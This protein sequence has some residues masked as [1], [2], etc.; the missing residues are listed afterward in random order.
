MAVAG[1]LT[2]SHVRPLQ[3]RQRRRPPP[4]AAEEGRYSQIGPRR[5]QR[6]HI[7]VTPPRP[8]SGRPLPISHA[9]PPSFTPLTPD[10]D[11]ERPRSKHIFALVPVSLSAKLAAGE[12]ALKQK[13]LSGNP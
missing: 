3:H 13:R 10:F 1:H 12:E 8:S 4:G 5:R 9:L 2:R 11:A 6:V 7:H